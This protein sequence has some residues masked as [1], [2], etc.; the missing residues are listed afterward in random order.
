MTDSGMTNIE[1]EREKTVQLLC[2]Y[3]AQ[4]GLSTQ[5][6]ESRLESAYRAANVD[7]LRALTVGLAP[8]PSAPVRAENE[9]RLLDDERRM[10]AMFGSVKRRGDWEPPSRT[11]AVAVCSELVLDFREARIHPGVTEVRVKALMSQVRIIVPPGLHV[12]C[13]GSAF[14]GE[15]ASKTDMSAYPGSGAP[16]LRITG[17]AVMSE[18]KVSV[19][20][21]D[22]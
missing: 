14:M 15:F 17:I 19:R 21:P 5:E 18:V 12:E 2:K 1:A 11:N 16:T 20:M 3:F 9:V 7:E 10:F 22:E 4:D 6:L 13:E 8:L